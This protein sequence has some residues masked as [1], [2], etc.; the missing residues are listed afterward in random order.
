MIIHSNA[1]SNSMF[2][3]L[4]MFA[5]ILSSILLSLKVLW[6]WYIYKYICLSA[7]NLAV[8]AIMFTSIVYY[9]PTIPFIEYIHPNRT[10]TSRYIFVS[11]HECNMDAWMIK[12]SIYTKCVI[13]NVT[14]SLKEIGKGVH[15]DVRYRTKQ[16]L[17]KHLKRFTLTTSI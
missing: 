4:Y 6:Y 8:W 11:Y 10:Y 15:Q 13:F 5:H 12:Q 1:I 9:D 7:G 16:Q 14:S 3:C 17:F 2:M